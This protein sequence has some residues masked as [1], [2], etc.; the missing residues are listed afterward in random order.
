M[1]MEQTKTTDKLVVKA[2]QV[3][4]GMELF[5]FHDM[6]T[7][8]YFYSPLRIT[9]T[10]LLLSSLKDCPVQYWPQENLPYTRVKCVQYIIFLRRIHAR[11]A[12]RSR[13]WPIYTPECR[14]TMQSWKCLYQRKY[15]CNT[16]MKRTSLACFSKLARRDLSPRNI[17]QISFLLINSSFSC[18]L[19]QCVP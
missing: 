5:L 13:Y 3:A 2:T 9:P 14:G 1:I 17:F 12:C 6:T 10:I 18:N 11:H 7:K 8:K 4:Q 15:N 19:A 16:T